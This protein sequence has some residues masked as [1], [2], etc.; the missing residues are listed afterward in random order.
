MKMEHIG[1]GFYVISSADAKKLAGGV[2]PKDGREK[3]VEHDG[4]NWWL[5]RTTHQSQSVW[6]IRKTAWRKEGNHLALG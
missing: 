3:L 5:A 6:S 1:E 4:F 2:F